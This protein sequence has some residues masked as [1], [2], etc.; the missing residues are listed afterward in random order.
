MNDLPEGWA[1]GT[2]G[3][4]AVPS[5]VGVSPASHLDLPYLGLAHVEAT[6]TR[7][8]GTSPA[9]W[10]RS[11]SY[12]FPAHSTLY[13]RLRPYLNKVCSPAFDGIGS[14]EFIVF[15]PTPHLAPGFLKYLLNQ[16]KFVEFTATLD[17]GDR[18]RV[19]WDGIRQFQSDLPPLAEQV[20]IVDAIEEEFSRLDAGM[21]ALERVRQNLQRMRAAAHLRLDNAARQS[22]APESLRAAAE[23]IVDGDHNPPQRTSEGVPYLT[24][25]HVKDGRISTAGATFVSDEDFKSLRKRYEPQGGDVLVTCVGTLG[26]VAVVPE[27]LTFAADRNLAAIRPSHDTDPRYLAAVLRSPRQQKILAAGSG[28]TAQ[29]HLYLKDLRAVVLSV[30]DREVQMELVEALEADLIGIGRLEATLAEITARSRA[31]RSAVLSAAFSGTLAPQDPADTPA[32]VLLTRLAA[33]RA[34][35]NGKNAAR[36][37]NTR[38]KVAS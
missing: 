5:R 26:E 12:H 31:L 2:L 36:V 29:P 30:P 6:T 19:K 3:D 13:A 9:S 28:S 27:G 14:G 25:K 1:R 8:L 11:T 15:L 21:A 24:A 32:S 34:S 10:V 4:F 17:T 20:R 35:S 37:P 23:F 18:P 16:P 7:I 22:T 38:T 33:E